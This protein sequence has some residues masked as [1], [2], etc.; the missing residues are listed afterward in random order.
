MP[1]LRK[2][3]VVSLMTV[4]VPVFVAMA[5]LALPLVALE[6]LWDFSLLRWHC[7]RTNVWTYLVCSPRRGWNEFLVNNVLP[8]IPSGLGCIWTTRQGAKNGRRA[9]NLLVWSGIGKAKPYLA[10]VRPFRV[11]YRS[12]NDRLQPLKSRSRVDEPTRQ[13]L[14]TLLGEE[15]R[16]LHSA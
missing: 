8:A 13:E 2:M 14:Q 10:E 11:R 4:L 16:N 15:L 3:L 1:K 6:R 12:L 7:W 5:I 9:E